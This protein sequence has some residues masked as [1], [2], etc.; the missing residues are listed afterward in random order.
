MFSIIGNNFGAAASAIDVR[1]IAT[2]DC[3]IL[4]GS[5]TVDTTAAQYQ[6]AE[7]LELQLE[8]V[9]IPDS[10]PSAVLLTVESGGLKLATIA[11]S[12]LVSQ[13]KLHIEKISAWN[14]FGSYKL[15]FQCA[16]FPRGRDFLAKS[17]RYTGLYLQNAPATFERHVGLFYDAGDYLF[18][19][20]SFLKFS[21]ASAGTPIE[22]T[23]SGAES[24]Q[25]TTVMLIYNNASIETDGS[26]YVEAV[27]GNGKLTV[28][29]GLP[30]EAL[31]GDDFKFFKGF[32]IP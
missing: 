19:S 16:Y 2:L 15:V 23:L 5:I 7:A 4:N 9:L 32:F 25:E 8:G 30:Q 6:T 12:Q 22:L 26:G 24:L 1:A 14:K 13:D 27:I 3:L 17:L 11:K 21:T 10:A 28:P 18:I 29:S 20:F 31:D